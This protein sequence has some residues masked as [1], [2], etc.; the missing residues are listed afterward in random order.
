MIDLPQKSVLLIDGIC[1]ALHFRRGREN[2]PSRSYERP[3]TIS[4][5][6]FFIGLYRVAMVAMIFASTSSCMQMHIRREFF[7]AHAAPHYLEV[8]AK[9][10]NCVVEKN[11]PKSKLNEGKIHCESVLPI[12][13]VSSPS[14]FPLPFSF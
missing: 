12:F 6:A 9:N 4:G 3:R 5:M 1:R 13:S 10:N 11:T 8:R 2:T 7:L 14:S